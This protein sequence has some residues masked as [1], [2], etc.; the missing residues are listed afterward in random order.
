MVSNVLTKRIKRIMLDMVLW[1]SAMIVGYLM[2]Y[3]S[4]L[5]NSDGEKEIIYYPDDYNLRIV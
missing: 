2:I 3:A 4:R 5:L 1:I